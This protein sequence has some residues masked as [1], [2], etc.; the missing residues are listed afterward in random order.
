M[1]FNKTK[2]MEAIQMNPIEIMKKAH[3]KEKQAWKVINA[4]RDAF[5]EDRKMVP[6]WKDTQVAY[7]NYCKAYANWKEI[8]QMYKADKKNPVLI[9][10]YL[11]AREKKAAV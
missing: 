6:E 10:A 2:Q 9:E 8:Y 7:R 4:A 11:N 5:E 1:Q 3:E